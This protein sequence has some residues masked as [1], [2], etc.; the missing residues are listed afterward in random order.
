MNGN[1]F[2]GVQYFDAI[3]VTERLYIGPQQS[4]TDDVIKVSSTKTDPSTYFTAGW[5]VS[6]IGL[7][8]NSATAIAQGVRGEGKITSAFNL[9]SP[10]YGLRGVTGVATH[11]GTGTITGAV[12]TI[13]VVQN[14]STGTITTA[15]ASLSAS[16]DNIGGGTITNLVGHGIANQSA[17]TNNTI[18]LLGTLTAPS[19]NYAIYNGSAYPNYLA[20]ATTVGSTLTVNTLTSGRVPYASTSGLLVDSANMT[21]S[22]TQLAL[23]STGSGGGLLIGGDAQWYRDS[24][25]IMR[26]PDS[27]RI[28]T[29][30]G[31]NAATSSLIPIMVAKTAS[32][33]ANY[34][35]ISGT[36]TISTAQTGGTSNYVGN[37]LCYINAAINS[38]P[39]NF[40]AGFN[41]EMYIQAGANNVHFVIGGQFRSRFSSGQ[42]GGTINESGGGFFGLWVDGATGFTSTLAYGAA[43]DLIA[44]SS[45]STGTVVTGYGNRTRVGGFSATN[46]T[47]FTTLYGSSIIPYLG[48]GTITTFTGVDV[49]NW[50]VGGSGA[51]TTG[52]GIRVGTFP[53]F[54]ATNQTR[55]GIDLPAMPSNDGSYLG[56]VVTA[57]RFSTGTRHQRNGMR[58]GTDSNTTIWSNA[59]DELTTDGKWTC[60]ALKVGTSSTTG[61]ALCASDANGNVTFQTVVRKRGLVVPLCGGFTPS[62]TGGDVLEFTMPYSPVDGTTSITWTLRRITLRVNVAGGAPAVT[63]EKS[64]ASGAFSAATMGSVTMGSGNYEVSATSGFTSST[65]ASGNKLRMNPTA[66]GT[67]TGWTVTCEFEEA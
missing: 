6:T 15:F 18:L 1:R 66:L 12:G 29:A 28:D 22:G 57:L 50:T 24:A 17:G 9:T 13:N 8:G 25:D 16:G 4:I 64:T 36:L 46:S 65:I 26:T 10:D 49:A 35:I 47:A 20:G 60:A 39:S 23:A 44:T 45:S 5:L 41:N 3:A 56:S 19:G 58:W 7:T 30:L 34:G 51:L 11:A 14:T 43:F 31:V 59:S 48:N 2:F 40:V 21:F 55:I 62:G 37:L 67:A 32:T 61:Q 53:N 42:T 52:Y 54:S 38:G 33:A 27:V 63:I